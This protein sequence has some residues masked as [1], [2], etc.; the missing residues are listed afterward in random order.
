MWGVKPQ[1]NLSASSQ[2]KAEAIPQAYSRLEA[3]AAKGRLAGE[4]AAMNAE[5]R[6]QVRWQSLFLRSF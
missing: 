5:L 3:A 6:V 4:L 1:N 2:E